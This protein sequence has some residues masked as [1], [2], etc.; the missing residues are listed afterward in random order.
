M[1]LYIYFLL[2]IDILDAIYPVV[3][4]NNETYHVHM[5]L[6][7]GWEMIDYRLLLNVT[8]LWHNMLS[9]TEDLGFPL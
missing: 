4:K 1:T 8:I 7:K 9:N 3:Y 5:E 2:S 6:W